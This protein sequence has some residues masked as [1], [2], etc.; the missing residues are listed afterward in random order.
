MSRY[1]MCGLAI[2]ALCATAA[3]AQPTADEAAPSAQEMTATDFRSSEL[4]GSTVYDQAGERIGTVDDVIIDA[5]GA[6]TSVII[7]V[8]GFL[9]LGEKNVAVPLKTLVTMRDEKGKI[10]VVAQGGKDALNTMP[11]F[12]PKT[13]KPPSTASPPPR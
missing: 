13:S 10:K 1:L 7:S 8:G 2:A 12:T 9:G 6:V 3:S 11:A 4:V 5:S